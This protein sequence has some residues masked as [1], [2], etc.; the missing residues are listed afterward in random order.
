MRSIRVRTVIG[1]DAPIEPVRYVAP[2]R[3]LIYPFRCQLLVVFDR[4]SSSISGGSRIS[5]VP[6][7][8]TASGGRFGLWPRSVAGLSHLARHGTAD[9]PNPERWVSWLHDG[10]PV[11]H[12]ASQRC[13]VFSGFGRAFSHPLASVCRHATLQT[14]CT[15][16]PRH[17]SV[18]PRLVLAY[19][20]ESTDTGS[21]A[22]LGRFPFR[23]QSATTAP[24]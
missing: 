4:S 5:H 12:D 3:R 15:E 20:Q 22:S 21:M 14:K 2:T 6:D 7:T 16:M 8:F 9:I 17:F 23:H 11:G 13:Y 24:I 19:G 18:P 1:A 10:P